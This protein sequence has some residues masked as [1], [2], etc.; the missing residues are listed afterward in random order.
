MS[1]S[2]L[3]TPSN[4]TANTASTN[5]SNNRKAL[6]QNKLTFFPGFNSIVSTKMHDLNMKMHIVERTGKLLK[7]QFIFQR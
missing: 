6:K 4:N 5:S 3:T 2:S 1:S 7:T